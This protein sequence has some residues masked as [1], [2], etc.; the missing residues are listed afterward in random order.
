MSCLLNFKNMSGCSGISCLSEY[1][2]GL[3]HDR[4]DTI[5]A[6]MLRSV[7]AISSIPFLFYSTG[8]QAKPSRTLNIAFRTSHLSPDIKSRHLYLSE[9]GLFII[10]IDNWNSR[11]I[12]SEIFVSVTSINSYFRVKSI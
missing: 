2:V 12:Y 11:V 1:V 9:M 3:A 7:H 6:I 8:H 5:I 4:K 10:V